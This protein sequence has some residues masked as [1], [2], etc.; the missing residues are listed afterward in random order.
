LLCR[1]FLPTPG[2]KEACRSFG[3]L[4]PRA[5]ICREVHGWESG[6]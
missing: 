2:E 4:H 6:R 5:M 3:I 1:R